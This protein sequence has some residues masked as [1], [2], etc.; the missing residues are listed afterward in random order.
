MMQEEPGRAQLGQVLLMDAPA[1]MKM[2]LLPLFHENCLAFAL[3]GSKLSLQLINILK[4]DTVIHV[5]K[6]TLQ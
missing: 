1:T 2:V 5:L 3:R 4:D 6:Y